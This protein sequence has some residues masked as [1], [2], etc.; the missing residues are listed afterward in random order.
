MATTGPVIVPQNDLLKSDNAFM[1]WLRKMVVAVN[2][3][4]SSTLNMTAGTLGGRG[5]ASG[6]GPLETITLGTNLSMTGTTLNATGGGIST[7][8]AKVIASYRA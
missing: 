4:I 8:V 7:E 2:S 3:T 6:A 1:D 5:A